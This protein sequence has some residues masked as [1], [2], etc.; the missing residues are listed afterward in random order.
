[1]ASDGRSFLVFAETKTGSLQGN[2]FPTEPSNDNGYPFLSN[3]SGCMYMLILEG[4]INFT[5]N[6]NENDKANLKYTTNEC[7]SKRTEQNCLEKGTTNL[8]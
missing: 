3:L 6:S 2:G 7:A 5:S 1:M 4:D 8:F